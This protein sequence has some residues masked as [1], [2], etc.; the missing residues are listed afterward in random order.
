MDKQY[1]SVPFEGTIVDITGWQAMQEEE[2]EKVVERVRH[3]SSTYGG[4]LLSSDH[5]QILESFPYLLEFFNADEAEKK[6]CVAPDSYSAYRGYWGLEEEDFSSYEYSKGTVRASMACIRF[7]VES[8]KV[9]P[10][11]GLFPN[12]W[13][14]QE[15]FPDFKE[16]VS[17]AID[18]FKDL[19][20]TL[21][22]VFSRYVLCFREIQRQ[23]SKR[24]ESFCE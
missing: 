4:F 12:F 17:K 11:L 15:K 19:H 9:A 2:K 5:K 13:P 23:D 24:S 14:E 20:E 6:K 10:E 1:R 18:N 7:G 3:C 16:K 22:Q 21:L 8:D